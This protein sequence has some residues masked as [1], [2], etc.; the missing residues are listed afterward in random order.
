MI[1]SNLATPEITVN[2]NSLHTSV[3]RQRLLM[4]HKARFNQI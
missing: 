4:A 3:E 2:I 1:H